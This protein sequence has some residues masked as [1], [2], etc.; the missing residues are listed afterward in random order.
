MIYILLQNNFKCSSICSVIM[1]KRECKRESIKFLIFFVIFKLIPKI[2]EFFINWG[3]SYINAPLSLGDK[4][5]WN[6]VILNV[7]KELLNISL[8]GEIWDS[9][10]HARHSHV[11]FCRGT[12][13]CRMHSKEIVTMM[14]GNPVV[15]IIINQKGIWKF[16]SNFCISSS[17]IHRITIF[18]A[19]VSKRLLVLWS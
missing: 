14:G 9:E 16:S 7:M 10:Y 11:K 5:C 3:N 18:W 1:K 2:S 17:Y 12:A 8:S 4:Y 6:T 13:P 15:I 19:W